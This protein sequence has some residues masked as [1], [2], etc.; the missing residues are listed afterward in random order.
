MQTEYRGI[1]VSSWQGDIDF[2]RVRNAG[3][4]IVYMQATE[5]TNYVDP[6]LDENYQGAKSVGLQVGFYHNLLAKTEEEARE[7]AAYFIQALSGKTSD[8]RLAVKLGNKAG[9]DNQT[10]SQLA[11]VFLTEVKALSGI[12]GVIYASTSTATYD[13]EPFLTKYPLWVA[14][15]GVSQPR[16]NG[17]WDTW[18]GWQYDNAGRVPGIH[19]NVNLDRFRQGILIDSKEIPQGDRPVSP[20]QSRVRYYMVRP[21]DTLGYIAG[22]FHTTVADLAKWNHIAN[23]NLLY[24]GQMLKI[25]TP[26]PIRGG[27]FES[28]YQVRPGETLSTIARQLGVSLRA[29]IAANELADPDRIYPGEVIKIP[30]RTGNQQAA[31]SPSEHLTD[32]YVVKPGD[33]L[34]YIARQFNTSV[35]ALVRLN[36]MKDPDLIYPGQVLKLYASPVSQ[37]VP[38]FTGSYI[39]QPGDTLTDI[40]EAFSTDVG[41]LARD[42]DIPNSN[43]IY[44]GQVLY[45]R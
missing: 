3:I 27:N 1:D 5:D 31:S 32:T 34:F 35:P 40:A 25:Y 39:V 16:P 12:D 6:Y 30:P 26:E 13:L 28:S 42:N 17:K 22:R 15:Y 38:D 33:S 43:M 2:S 24:P 19:G 11:D 18:V 9:L 37:T 41:T 36:G 4:Q 7:E 21:G 8:C 23:I 45:V 14:E 20:Y 44:P 29:L 10:F